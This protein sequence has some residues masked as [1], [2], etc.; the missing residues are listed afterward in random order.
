MNKELA[1]LDLLSKS[2]FRTRVGASNISIPCPLAKYS[3][4]HKRSYDVK[5]SMGIKVTE[6][7]VLVN[8]FT[9]GFK[10][11]QL[12]YLYKRLA[13]HN[14]KAWSVALNKCHE[15]EKQFLELGL[16]NLSKT[17]YFKKP[18]PPPQPI[19]ESEWAQYGNMFSKYFLS[20]N[21]TLET[22]K[23]WGVGVD[24][25]RN[26]AMIPIRDFKNNL[27]GAVGRAI[28]PGKHDPKYFN[29][30]QFKKSDHLLGSQ[31]IK[32]HKKIV[33]VEGS[34]DAMRADQAIMNAG[35]QDQYGVV[36]ILGSKLSDKQAE[37]LI[38][39]SLEVV[40]AFDYDQAG[41][42][43]MLQ[44]HKKLNKKIMTSVCCIGDVARKDFGECN[45]E[46]ILAVISNSRM[47]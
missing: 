24:Q 12:S 9:C 47:F 15:L 46:E 18:E 38:K 10:C 31:L 22:G 14:Q 20:R 42:D 16:S 2:G 13:S 27:W 26:R 6:S 39:C 44:A 8:C 28:N 1:V 17:G 7:A 43:G 4:L 23:R 36:S 21:I 41:Y 33:V 3:P 25:I 30:W 45:D 40:L 19:D 29:Y 35:M 11:G 37:I 34:M 32:S 5:P